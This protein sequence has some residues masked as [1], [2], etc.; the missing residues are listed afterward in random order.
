MERED[1]EKFHEAIIRN[2]AA[3]IREQQASARDLAELRQWIKTGS[4]SR[5]SDSADIQALLES[6]GRI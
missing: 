4:N 2:P 1:L 6:T 3:Q 5:Q